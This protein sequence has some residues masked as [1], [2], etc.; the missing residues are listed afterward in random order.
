MQL[1]CEHGK[2]YWQTDNGKTI[3]RYKNGGTEEFDNSTHDK[4]RYE[5]FRD[6]V[7]AVQQGHDPLCTP[8]LART[9]SLTINAMHES[10]TEIT[11]ISEEYVSEVEDWEMFPPNTKGRFRRVRGMDE[12]MKVALEER[13][14]FSE[15]EIPWA[16]PSASM[17]FTV[18]DYTRFPSSDA[19][20]DARPQDLT[21]TQ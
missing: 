11:S 3:V 16:K 12:Y 8:E 4:W 5:G 2:A 19:Q 10:C 21:V 14:F 13:C 1:D 7:L 20:A 17:P 18:R 6:F 15:L 9:H